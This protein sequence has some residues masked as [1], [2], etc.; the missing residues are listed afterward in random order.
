[1]RINIDSYGNYSSSNYGAHAMRVGIGD[2]VLW[3]SYNKTIIAFQ[4]PGKGIKVSKNL[5]GPT[6]GKHLNA[7]DNGDKQNRLPRA[8]FEQELH[9]LLI[10]HNLVIG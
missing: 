4:A 8:Q 10:K 3:F 5:W 7:I 1:M 6:T 2:L 9:E